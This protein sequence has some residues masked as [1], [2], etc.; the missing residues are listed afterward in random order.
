MNAESGASRWCL[1]EASIASRERPGDTGFSRK[2]Y[3]LP[4][5]IRS[6]S[7]SPSSRRPAT[8]ATSR[9]A[10]A[11]NCIVRSSAFVPTIAASTTATPT[12]F[13]R[14]ASSACAMVFAYMTLCRPRADSFTVVRN[15]SS[16][17][18]TRTST[19]LEPTS[20]DAETLAGSRIG[21]RPVPSEIIVDPFSEVS[22][23][24]CSPAGSSTLAAVSFADSARVSR[25]AWRVTPSIRLFRDAGVTSPRTIWNTSLSPTIAS[26]P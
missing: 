2:R 11:R 20:A 24:M 8:I 3:T 14:T 17:V 26:R 16:C 21:K 6:I 19:A 13:L 12:F 7:I 1:T 18:R 22:I 25:R 9:G 10:A 15:S 5:L 23:T 4:R